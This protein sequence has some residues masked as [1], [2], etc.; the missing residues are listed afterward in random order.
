M[1]RVLNAL[2]GEV[3]DDWLKAEKMWNKIIT[4]RNDPNPE[5]DV[6]PIEGRHGAIKI[7]GNQNIPGRVN[8]TKL[9]L[10]TYDG[11]LRM[12]KDDRF[13]PVSQMSGNK[14]EMMGVSVRALNI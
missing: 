6:L 5:Y 4:A 11:T 8:Q 7:H 3:V 10:Q 13:D 9:R 2:R 14:L 12:V 1:I